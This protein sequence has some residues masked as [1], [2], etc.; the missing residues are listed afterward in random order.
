MTLRLCFFLM[1]ASASLLPAN[2]VEK[3]LNHLE[4]QV[5]EMQLLLER[6]G[7]KTPQPGSQRQ[8]PSRPSGNYHIRK[9]DS[10]WSIARR[11]GI[12]V[13]DLEN[14]NPGLH[15]R[16]LTIGQAIT[17]PGSD[18]P[19]PS[20]FSRT[21]THRIKKGEIMGRVAKKY[22]ITLR[23]LM[24]ANR[25]VNPRRL[26]I[27]S[28]LTIPGQARTTPQPLPP[29]ETKS[30]LPEAPAPQASDPSPPRGNPYLKA[31]EEA[32]PTLD[33]AGPIQDLNEPKLVTL[34]EDTRFSK[35]ASDHQT[36]VALLN[37]LNHRDLSPEQ[38]IKAGSQLYIP[39]R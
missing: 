30:G 27:G 13:A 1:L 37:K 39:G 22:G 7:Q 28:T 16:R 35:I 5:S 38:M 18:S 33:D 32:P 25:G 34:D 10:Y 29:V 2:N 4:N 8:T 17:I 19:L 9:G 11:H 36:T 24:N 21:T 12:S 26:R 15:P 23:Q 31:L 20:S 3:R 14:A 6:L